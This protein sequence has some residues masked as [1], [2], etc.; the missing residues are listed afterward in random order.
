MKPNLEPA[1][2]A[3]GS[4]KPSQ[5]TARHHPA[6]LDLSNLSGPARVR[7]FARGTTLF[8]DGERCRTLYQLLSGAVKLYKISFDG[9][10]QIANF[11]YAGDIVGLQNDGTHRLSAEAASRV[12]ALSFNRAA[13]D[14]SAG[15]D[16]A[17]A[18]QLWHLGLAEIDRAHEQLVILGKRST[19]E[20]FAW[21]LLDLDERLPQTARERGALIIPMSRRDMANYLGLSMETVC[22]CFTR[23][24]TLGL[25]ETP[26]Y[27]RVRLLDRALLR[28]ISN[29]GC[30][31]NRD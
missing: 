28:D 3:V 27:N 12:D 20:R 15:Q 23:L 31:A 16:S 4:A 2:T 14:R 7:S 13:L 11:A 10:I 17:L 1:Y 6:G 5:R 9:R 8:C 30:L 22:R 25:I 18:L 19:M 29:E 26:K 21:F 24:R